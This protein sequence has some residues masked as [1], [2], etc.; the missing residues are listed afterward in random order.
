M[1]LRDALNAW[2]E[3]LGDAAVI[4]AAAMPARYQR[5]TSGT[6]R[7]PA[8]LLR[9]ASVDDIRAAVRIASRFS[10]PLHPISTGHNW[11]YGSALAVGEGCVVVDLGSMAAIRDFDADLGV[12]TVEP[13][14]TQR[15]LA[16]YLRAQNAPFLVPVTGA[17][18]TCSV[19]ANAL[20]RGYGITPV[21]DHALAIMAIEAVLP[22]GELLKPVLADLGAADAARSF[23]WGIGPYLTGLFTQGSLGIVTAMTIALA[24]RPEAIQAFVM[25]CGEGV[26][27]EAIVMA[28][29]EL[30]RRLPGV[31]GGI[32]VMNAHR[33]LAMS[34]DY[35][36]DRLGADGLIPVEVLEELRRSRNIAPWTVYGTLYGTKPVVAAARR[37]VRALLRPVGG[38]LLFLSRSVVGAMRKVASWLPTGMRRR[39]A[40]MADTL[41]A[42][43]EL[44]EGNP[45]E[46]ALPL[47]Y[48]LSGGH[49]KRTAPLDPAR[50]GCGLLWYSPL[51]P[52]RPDTV[53]RYLDFVVA[54]MRRHGFEPL[55]TLTTLS[56]R[57]FD[58][59]VPLLF[60]AGSA[61]AC[62]RAR[63]CY[64]DLLEAG[65]AFGFLPYRVHIDA[66]SWLTEQRSM[67]WEIVEKIKRAVDPV[68]IIAPGRY[69]PFQGR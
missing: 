7:P 54:T 61:D 43:L 5:C 19:L 8:A 12:I 9:P 6:V 50:D 69:A 53:R 58:S 42:S 20:E 31:I 39:F 3:A 46:T 24:R 66:M 16:D 35:P 32:N 60:D 21:A 4:E 55:V 57:C 68:G 13:G 26:A 49:G 37:L 34:A 10:V 63:A 17:G 1:S 52:M 44:V 51:I 65:R 40:P 11:G 25:R 59:S 56:E 22:N 30:V 14:V 15:Q 33:V 2:R 36:R 67:H 48:W 62:R 64:M 27:P 41:A 28:V 29:R 38:R 47:A 18:P 45:N 23:R